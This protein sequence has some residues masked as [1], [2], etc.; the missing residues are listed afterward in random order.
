[1]GAIKIRALTVAD[2]D[3]L[4]DMIKKLVAELGSNEILRYMV[5]ADPTEGQS[6]KSEETTDENQSPDKKYAL[7]VIEIIKKAIE[8]MG[9]DVR[10]WFSDL[11]GVTVEEFKTLPI[12]TE[13]EI[14]EQL[15]AAEESN[16]FFSR[17]LALS[18]KIKVLK[19]RLQTKREE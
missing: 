3:R 16:R 14:I 7:L 5:S 8:V 10:E 1:M 11:I 15:V 9:S 12:D 2:R 18:S 4:S 13:V 6:Q 19:S 17:L